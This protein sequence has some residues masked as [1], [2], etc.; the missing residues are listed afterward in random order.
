MPAK[1]S[2]NSHN[3]TSDSGQTGKKNIRL[4]AAGHFQVAVRNPISSS[5]GPRTKVCTLSKNPGA[6][7]AVTFTTDTARHEGSEIPVAAQLSGL[8]ATRP[9]HLEPQ[10]GARRPTQTH[11]LGDHRR[12]NQVA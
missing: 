2:L 7:E 11:R 9:R 6:A 3:E 8:R 10:S 5:Q 12:G 1:R 4:S